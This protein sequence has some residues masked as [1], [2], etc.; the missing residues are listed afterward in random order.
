MAVRMGKPVPVSWTGRATPPKVSR[1]A[2]LRSREAG[3]VRK[4][5]RQQEPA[6]AAEVLPQRRSAETVL[7]AITTNST[8]GLEGMRMKTPTVKLLVLAVLTLSVGILAFRLSRC[9][10]ELD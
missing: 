2:W 6:T 9:P 1:H 3:F 7:I 5:A 4:N 8:T 10:T